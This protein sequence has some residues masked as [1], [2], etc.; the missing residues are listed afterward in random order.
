MKDLVQ[1]TLDKIKKEKITPTPKWMFI[2]KSVVVWLSFFILFSLGIISF[3][4]VIYFANQLDWDIDPRSP[5]GLKATVSVLPYF[6]IMLF[7]A[8]LALSLTSFRKTK[9]G[10]R[11]SLWKIIVA[12][13]LFI[14]SL[15][16]L[17]KF[18]R[19]SERINNLFERS[20]P[21]YC[22]QGHIKERQWSQPGFGFLG[23]KVKSKMNSSFG[24]EDFE[25]KTWEVLYD[26]DT[27]FIENVFPQLEELIRVMGEKE[28]K[29][30]FRAK[31]IRPWDN[32]PCMKEGRNFCLEKHN[33]CPK[34]RN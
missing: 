15:S 5:R 6:W 32:T 19:G 13:V 11:Y 25:G 27:V 26:K 9:S 28:G 4:L 24:M 3:L 31:V 18:T 29:S 34:P 16:A 1:K 7:S 2:F 23:G 14:A 22:H 20:L 21:F 8:F 30:K 12:I 17:D 10:Y 33:Q